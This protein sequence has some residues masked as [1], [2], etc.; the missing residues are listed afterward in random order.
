MLYCIVFFYHLIKTKSNQKP[1]HLVRQAGAGITTSK[2]E[3]IFHTASEGT[4]ETH[5][6]SVASPP[7][8]TFCRLSA[9]WA[10]SS[11]ERVGEVLRC[12]ESWVHRHW[13][14]LEAMRNSLLCN[15]VFDV[16]HNCHSKHKRCGC[17][18]GGGHCVNNFVVFFF[19]FVAFFLARHFAT[20]RT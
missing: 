11:S 10:L 2:A 8:G 6:P 4:Q 13:K 9:G 1:G 12:L 7:A 18:P 3:M 20:V 19:F 5:S 16:T 17:S 15:G 14:D